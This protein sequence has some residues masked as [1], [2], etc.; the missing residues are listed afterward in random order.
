MLLG[1]R[2]NLR[3]FTI[4]TCFLA[5]TILTGLFISAPQSHQDYDELSK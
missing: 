4:G 1:S 3:F 2:M 5:A